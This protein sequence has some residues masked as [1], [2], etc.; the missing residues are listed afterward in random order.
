M[1]KAKNKFLSAIALVFCIFKL[2]G[3]SASLPELTGRFVDNASV[4]K[5]DTAQKIENSLKTLEDQTG[6]QFAVLTVKSLEEYSI[7]EYA[8]LVFE[9]WHLGQK[10]KDNGIL[11]VLA[12]NE[13]KVRIE[14]GYGMEQVLTDTKCGLI[15]RNFMIPSFKQKNFEEG[16]LLGVEKIIGYVQGSKAVTEEV[17]SLKDKK[18]SPVALIP[19]L[20]W[21]IFVSIIVISNI[22]A[23]RLGLVP[24]VVI[25]G[26][27]HD[28]HDLHNGG[29]GGFSGGGFHGGGG[30]SGGGGASGSW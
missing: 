29:F 25:G 20:L 14:T 27:P 9:K 11:L 6:I 1:H 24:P 28:R 18:S 8:N 12:M 30:R 10:E 21:V 15:I 19:V 4:A 26:T 23:K 7:E 13:Q 17:D 16:L 22:R 2:S 5:N 3:Q